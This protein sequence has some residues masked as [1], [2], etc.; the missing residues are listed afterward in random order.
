MPIFTHGYDYPWPDGRGVISF[1]GWKIGPWFDDTF[2]HKNYP[3]NN[4]ND[5]K[6]RHDIMLAFINSLNA[7]L[8]NLASQ[9]KYAGKLFHVNLIGTLLKES[10][11]ANELHPLNPG[12]SAIADKIDVALQA[13]I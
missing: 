9:P 11:W 1:L 3:N 13:H 6:A 7:M 4:A 8:A 2:N 12:F 10:E 5:L